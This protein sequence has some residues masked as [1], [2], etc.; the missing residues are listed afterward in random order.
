MEVASARRR[1][2]VRFLIDVA[3]IFAALATVPLMIAQQRVGDTAWLDAG[4]W[5]V[6]A[7]FLIEFTYLVG[8]SSDR[9]KAAKRQWTGAVIIIVSFPLLPALFAATRLVRLTRITR[10]VRLFRL[11]RLALVAN[12][13]I[14][15]LKAVTGQYELLFMCAAATFFIA[16]S[17]GVLAIVEPEHGGYWDSLW[18]AV[19]TATTVGYGDIAPQTFVGR[20]AAGVLMLVGIGLVATLAAAI[21]QHLMTDKSEDELIELKEQLN[22]IEAALAELKEER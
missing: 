16:I 17:A 21:T 12:R 19:V 3:V 18:W 1:T 7:I 6:W 11:F 8:V 9:W 15:A 14:R 20:I 13:G 10:L 5:I 22:R 2:D 4:D